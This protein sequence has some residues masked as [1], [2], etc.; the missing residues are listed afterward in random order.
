MYFDFTHPPTLNWSQTLP[1]LPHPQFHTHTLLPQ[2]SRLFVWAWGLPW[3]VVR[4]PA[5]QTIRLP[6]PGS[7]QMSLGPQMSL[8]ASSPPYISMYALCQFIFSRQSWLIHPFKCGVKYWAGERESSSIDWPFILSPRLALILSPL[9]DFSPNIFFCT[10]LPPCLS[11][12][13]C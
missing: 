12:I 7:S 11:S 9:V 6:L 8:G 10:W 3:I 2:Q 1:H 13:I 5:C 4:T